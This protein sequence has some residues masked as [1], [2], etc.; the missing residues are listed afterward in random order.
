ME[1]FDRYFWM[2]VMDFE[3]SDL[4]AFL[5]E[6]MGAEIV[7]GTIGCRTRAPYGVVV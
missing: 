3:D 5:T 6:K 2:I 7:K 4:A 1:F